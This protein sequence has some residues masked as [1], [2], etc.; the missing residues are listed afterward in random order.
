[1]RLNAI[2]FSGYPAGVTDFGALLAAVPQP[3]LA[4][5]DDVM[6]V[7][8]GQI[9]NPVPNLHVSLIIVG[10]SDRQDRGDFSCDQRRASEAEAASDRASSAWVYI[11][12]KVNSKVVQAGGEAG[13]W[14]E[15]SPH[16][17]WAQV[18]AGA[19][20]LLHNP[21]TNAQRPLNRRVVVLVSVFNPD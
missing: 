15:T 13:P 1:M 8:A 4:Q 6:T 16:V 12:E 14:W 20:M 9:V 7:V 17:T 19:G 2:T 3:G 21:P 10:H 11:R 18:Y 5:L